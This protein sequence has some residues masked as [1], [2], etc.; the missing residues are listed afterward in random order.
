MK[1]DEYLIAK[2]FGT[3][4]TF[5]NP[6]AGEYEQNPLRTLIRL[7]LLSGVPAGSRDGYGVV[8]LY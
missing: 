6:D 7:T 8:W 4:C 1:F 2:T 3:Q 5:P